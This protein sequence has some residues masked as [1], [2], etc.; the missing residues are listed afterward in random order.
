MKINGVRFELDTGAFVTIS[1]TNFCILEC[2][3]GLLRI[4]DG[5]HNNGGWRLSKKYSYQ[6]VIEMIREG[7]A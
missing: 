7:T 6:Q 1:A 2:I 5:I 3:D 4:E